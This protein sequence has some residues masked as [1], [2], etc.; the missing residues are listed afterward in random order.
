VVAIPEG[1]DVTRCREGWRVRTVELE[2][3]HGPHGRDERQRRLTGRTR[4]KVEVLVSVQ[5]VGIANL[6][7]R[8][9]VL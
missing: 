1:G 4:A 2:L 9:G 3:N 6:D 7:V 5:G 8:M